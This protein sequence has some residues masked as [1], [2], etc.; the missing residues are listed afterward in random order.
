MSA[1]LT[2]TQATPKFCSNLDGYTIRMAHRSKIR[3]SLSNT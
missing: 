1:S 3:N 2:P